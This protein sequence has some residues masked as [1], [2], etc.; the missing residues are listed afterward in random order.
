MCNLLKMNVSLTVP[1]HIIRD[2]Q[3]VTTNLT[4]LRGRISHT[5]PPIAY[6]TGLQQSRA[7][8]ASRWQRYQRN[9]T[10]FE[11]G[12]AGRVYHILLRTNF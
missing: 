4:S 10:I 6:S 12:A 1:V 7:V 2:R 9:D 11:I 5:C 3:F 8:D